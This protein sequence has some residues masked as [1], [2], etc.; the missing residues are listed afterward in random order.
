MK[1]AAR[2]LPAQQPLPT[3]LVVSV[4]GV[5]NSEPPQLS[6]PPPQQHPAQEQSL[7]C[8]HEE[9]EE[10]EDVPQ[11]A[12]GTSL[13]PLMASA[14]AADYTGNPSQAVKPANVPQ[15]LLRVSHEVIMAAAEEEEEEE[16]VWEAVDQLTVTR[17]THVTQPLSQRDVLQTHRPQ[18]PASQPAPT[19]GL[20]NA[21]ANVPLSAQVPVAAAF[22]VPAAGAAQQ[23]ASI[24]DNPELDEGWLTKQ[25]DDFL[26]EDDGQDTADGMEEEER[27]AASHW[28]GMPAPDVVGGT[29][30]QYTS[31]QLSQQHQDQTQVPQEAPE[32]D[33]D[34]ELEAVEAEDQRLRRAQAK[35]ARGAEA[36][37]SEMYAE[38]QELLQLFGL[39][40]IVAPVEVCGDMCVR[41]A[42]VGG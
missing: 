40:F 42:C 4:Q 15:Q 6:P 20:L 10:W 36:P 28:H 26:A 27:V 18:A 19:P 12:P 21:S 30:P 23:R 25:L 16:E 9:D 13:Q 22:A 41:C 29:A 11:A 7:A 33:L 38:C 2:L 34:M 32:L 5:T 14:A 24:A 39:P 35:A 31:P 37:T 1:P 8:Q 17:A 3:S